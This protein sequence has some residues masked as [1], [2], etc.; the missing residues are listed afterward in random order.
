M[1]INSFDWPQDADGDV[2]RRM[3]Q[4]G[5]DFQKPCLID[6][7]VDFRNWPPE[8]DAIRA[9]KLQFPSTM[10]YQPNSQDPGYIQFQMLE[11]LTYYLVIRIQ[12]QVTEMMAPYG[13]LCESW[14]VLH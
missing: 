7:N 8:Q 12:D 9:M 11:L 4:A 3:H 6:F 10:I 13:G 14:G 1:N 5:F 2:L